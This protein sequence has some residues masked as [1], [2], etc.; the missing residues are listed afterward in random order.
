[1]CLRVRRDTNISHRRSTRNFALACLDPFQG[2]LIL[3]LIE[4]ARDG[5]IVVLVV[6]VV[7]FSLGRFFLLFLLFGAVFPF[8]TETPWRQSIA[9]LQ[10]FIGRLRTGYDPG[11]KFS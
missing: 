2:L 4:L 5:F 9:S 8:R 10:S 11:F 3:V 6:V 1:M 7:I